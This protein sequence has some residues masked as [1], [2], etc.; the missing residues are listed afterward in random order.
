[1]RC[2]FAVL[3]TLAQLPAAEHTGTVKFGG[4]PVPGA[5]VFATQGGR[6]RSTITNSLGVYSFADLEEG[7]CAV[8]VEMQLFVPESREIV[9]PNGSALEWELTAAPPPAL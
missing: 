4:L 6:T 7:A 9:I 8:R 1:M 2:F 3:L 5:S